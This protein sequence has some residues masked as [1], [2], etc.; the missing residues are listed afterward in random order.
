MEYIFVNVY[1]DRE[2]LVSSEQ[3]KVSKAYLEAQGF[4]AD[5]TKRILAEL[6]A[7]HPFAN[8]LRFD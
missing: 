8:I 1:N 2:E 5:E 3:V 7:R 6:Q 4:I